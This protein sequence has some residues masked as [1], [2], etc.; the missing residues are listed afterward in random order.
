MNKCAQS[1]RLLVGA[2]LVVSLSACSTVGGWFSSDDE[3]PR[4]PAPLEDIQTEISIKKLWSTG[5]GS[6]QGKIFNRLY[7]A[8][9][10]DTIY[11]AGSDGTVAAL[12]RENGKRIW[13]VD[14]DRDVSGAVGV[15][16]GKVFV[17]TSGGVLIALDS[18]TGEVVWESILNGEIL[19][20]AQS[21]GVFVVVQT[22]DGKLHG[23]SAEDGSELWLYDSNLPVLTLR[24]TS[25][26]LIHEK[27]AIAGFANGRVQAFDISTGGV[28]WEA[29]V[30]IAQGRSEIDRIVDVDGTLLESSG[31]LYA[32]SYQGRVV[33]LDVTSGRKQWQEDVSSYVGLDQGFGNVYV[34]DEEG[35]VIAFYK[36]GQG[37]RWENPALEY[38]QL[39]A[40]AVVR[41]YVAVGDLE[42]YVHFLSQADGKFVG[43]T[44]VDGDG[45]RGNMLVRDD[46]LYVLGN[47]GTLVA[48]RVT[49]R[50]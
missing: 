47:G 18:A 4:E 15:G 29:R 43:R 26:P 5:V 36:N 17:G 25:T 50:K 1:L 20:P 48:L 33:S 49:A 23:L 14:L 8:L 12:D 34:A 44:K 27:L 21:D 39:S 16:G 10:G 46:V 45:V 31:A 13:R 28:R 38:R 19:A 24:G 35:S 7:P 6:G 32:V 2:G 40:P 22:Y 3:D 42:G 30:A 37:V 41:G 11:A 9:E